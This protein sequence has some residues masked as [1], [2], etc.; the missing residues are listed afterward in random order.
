MRVSGQGAY[1]ERRGRFHDRGH[2]AGL[3]A[4]LPELRCSRL[5]QWFDGDDEL[6]AGA[7]LV[8]DPTDYAVD[9]Q[10]WV[11][12]AWPAGVSARVA[13]APR[14]SRWRGWPAAT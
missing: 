9:E 14:Y 6:V 8:P 10:D 7:T 1:R 13:A 5:A 4:E 2:E 3:V 11:V 12:P